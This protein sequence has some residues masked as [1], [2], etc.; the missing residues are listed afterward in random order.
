MKLAIVLLL[1][2]AIT[3]AL[4]TL[5]PQGEEISYYYSQYSRPFARIIEA[6]HFHTFFRS[7]AFLFPLI[8]FFINLFVCAVDRMMRRLRSRARRRFGP[9]IVHIGLLL[10]MV[11]GLIGMYGREESMVWLSPGESTTLE[12]GYELV[13]KSF[14]FQK[15]DDG[16]PKDWLSQV[17]VMKDEKLVKTYTIEVNHPLS[18][19]RLK[20]FQSSYS[21]DITADISDFTG[22]IVTISPGDYY[23]EENSIV[24]FRTVEFD[25]TDP[26]IRNGTPC[27]E[28]AHAVFEELSMDSEG[29]GH[30]MIAVHRVGI[31]EKIGTFTIEKLCISSSTGLQ[32][33]K[34]SSVAPIIISL[35]LIGMGLSLTFAQKMGDQNL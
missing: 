6:V 15:Y 24:I 13:L 19:G 32:V 9:D 10:L 26:A 4:S 33:T 5:I 23:F 11:S 14:D 12:D 31:D 21:Q 22:E 16:R 2:L 18:I 3:S 30:E 7:F 17:D 20:V 8:L 35:A 29:S 28:S 34:D 1:Y 25:Q 27:P